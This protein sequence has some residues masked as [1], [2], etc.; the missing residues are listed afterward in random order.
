MK[1]VHIVFGSPAINR[2]LCECIRCVGANTPLRCSKSKVPHSE[3]KELFQIWHYRQIIIEDS[4]C[5]IEACLFIN[6]TLCVRYFFDGVNNISVVVVVLY[7][8]LVKRSIK[9]LKQDLCIL[10]SIEQGNYSKS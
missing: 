1:V 2:G 6:Y 9:F 10:G 7:G 4:E 3:L 5:Y 8:G